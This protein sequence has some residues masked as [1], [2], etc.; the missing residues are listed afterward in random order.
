MPAAAR[1]RPLVIALVLALAGIAASGCKSRGDEIASK[2]SP[3]EMYKKAAADLRSGNYKGAS[4]KL[5]QLMARYPFSNAAKQGQL[6][7]MYAYYKNYEAESAIDQ[8]D[9]FIRENPTHP[10]VD[11]AYYIRGLVYFESG[12]GWLERVFN[13]DVTKR[14]PSEAQKSLQAFQ[15]LLER[16]PKSP[17]AADARQRMVFLRNRLADYE[18]AVAKYYMKRGAYV[19]AVSRARAVI[20]TYDGSPAALTA[21]QIMRDG[22]KALGIDELAT[23]AD[24]V[25]AANKDL[26]NIVP[27]ATAPAG[28]AMSGADVGGPK[29]SAAAREGRWEGRL[30]FVYQN[31]SSTD[32][33]GGTTVDVASG[34]GFVGGV[35]YHFTDRLA[36]GVNLSYDN[37][38]YKAKVAG[39]QE[40]E[41]YP[42]KG[43]LTTTSLMF[44]G[45]YNFLTG[46]FTPLVTAGLGWSSVDTNVA[47]GPPDVG[48][49]WSP[50]YGYIC[51][52]WQKTKTVSGFSYELGVGVR[53]DFN[54]Y[55]AA[56]GIYKMKWINFDNAT[57]TPQYDG[58]QMNLGWKF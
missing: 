43:D 45:S 54:D 6:D 51:T 44:D 46:P 34:L 27:P 13:A 50:W 52:A 8:A 30:G 15:T 22:Y 24:E 56:D 1:F 58:F 28:L 23:R 2:E 42:I 32:F 17:Y 37:K 57:G 9:Q 25:Y 39:D 47:T 10:R 29:Y 3:D 19:A 4:D 55:L 20:E 7:L 40:G 18:L 21:L 26:P 16:Y 36:A 41:V 5:S 53:Y 11:Y 49:W 12:A 31:S 38:S 48:C 33:K 35:D 14:P